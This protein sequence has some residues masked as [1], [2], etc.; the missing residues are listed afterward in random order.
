M[1]AKQAQAFQNKE[2]QAEEGSQ[3]QTDNLRL[4]TVN[5]EEEA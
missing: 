4:T 2:Q 1:S 5:D 3:S